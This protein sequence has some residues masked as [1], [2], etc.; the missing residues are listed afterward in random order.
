MAE[1][2]ERWTGRREDRT[3]TGYYNFKWQSPNYL[4]S[5]FIDFVFWHL[6]NP[7]KNYWNNPSLTSGEKFLRDYILN[8]AYTDDD[9]CVR[10]TNSIDIHEY[11]HDCWNWLIFNIAVC[12]KIPTYDEIVNSD[13]DDVTPH[14][15]LE[16]N[17][18]DDEREL[19]EHDAFE[20]KYNFRFEDPDPEFV[21]LPFWKHKSRFIG[22]YVILLLIKKINVL[23]TLQIKRY[24]RDIES[25][26]RRKDT[27]RT[28]KRKEVLDRKKQVRVTTHLELVDVLVVSYQSVFFSGKS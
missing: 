12:S 23:F 25:S 28:D 24:P 10:S 9:R 20:V 13:D 4:F 16:V 8:K 27:S 5:D 15:N 7:L 19:E 21:S 6:K 22:N 2:S 18:S 11:I 26:M 3:R 14:F 17:A 1:R